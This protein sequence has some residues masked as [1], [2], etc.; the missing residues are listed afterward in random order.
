MQNN[1][2]QIH[3]NFFN[4]D[5]LLYLLQSREIQDNYSLFLQK[6][7]LDHPTPF[8][9]F[10]LPIQNNP[11]LSN[12]HSKLLS[13]FPHLENIDAIPMKWVIGDVPPHAD[14]GS[15]NFTS[16]IVIYLTDD[17]STFF[18]IEEGQGDRL[19]ISH[20][21][22]KNKA[23]IFPFGAIHSVQTNPDSPAIPRLMMGPMSEIGERVGR[24]EGYYYFANYDDAYNFTNQL[25][26]IPPGPVDVIQSPE[27][28]ALTIPTG[29]TFVG[30]LNS[31]SPN[32]FG[33]DNYP[34]DHLYTSGEDTYNAS[35]VNFVIGL[36]PEFAI[37]PP[38][39]PTPISNV[40]FLAGSMV[41]TNKGYVAIESVDKNQ[42]LIYPNKK[43][44]EIT[45]TQNWNESLLC[46]SKDAFGANIPNQQ[47][48]LTQNHKILYKNSLIKVGKLMEMFGM[49]SKS[50][51]IYPVPY[52]GEFLY[53]IL[54]EKSG[55]M[56]VNNL[57][58]ETLDP[59][60]PIAI[61][62]RD[63]LPS[64]PADGTIDTN[65]IIRNFNQKQIQ[66]V[67]KNKKQNKQSF[68]LGTR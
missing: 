9:Y 53:N 36:Y 63:I 6:Q 31:D 58:C 7:Q 44:V 1:N 3:S 17:E 15:Q 32:N 64:L 47:T 27:Q 26:Y 13:Y 52:K 24:I 57:T 18:H 22:Q 40:C 11:L 5:D 67:Q 46:I 38:T 23:F 50:S 41:L 62:Y 35:Y 30:W 29:Y 10:S 2:I 60:N 8:H 21:I 4:D 33:T 66:N 48:I 25:S 49:G 20:S 28:T 59:Q 61:L 14:K 34:I 51:P 39:P 12:I 54:L 43:I 55:T 65:I 56:I 68:L 16:S 45:K 42:H 37:I 19:T